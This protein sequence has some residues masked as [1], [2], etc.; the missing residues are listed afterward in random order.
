MSDGRIFECDGIQYRFSLVVPLNQTHRT[1]E[2]RFKMKCQELSLGD[3]IGLG[4]CG[5]FMFMTCVFPCIL[6]YFS[7]FHFE[8]MVTVLINCCKAIRNLFCC[9][10]KEPLR[11]TPLPTRVRPTTT[12]DDFDNSSTTWPRPPVRPLTTPDG[13]TPRRGFL[14]WTKSLFSKSNQQQQLVTSETATTE[15]AASTRSRELN[16]GDSVLHYTLPMSDVENAPPVRGTA[17]RRN[18]EETLP[19]YRM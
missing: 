16:M 1:T 7:P 10:W 2:P 17:Y 9:Y 15:F 14:A 19:V 5:G 12:Y 4:V 18:T 11:Y 3:K 13:S 8:R 6:A